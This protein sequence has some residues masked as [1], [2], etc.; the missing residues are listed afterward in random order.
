MMRV[1]VYEWCCSG[2]ARGD[3]PRA[4]PLMAEGWAMLTAAVVDFRRVAGVE[5]RTVLDARLRDFPEPSAW[6]DI[7][8]T[9]VTDDEP[10]AFRAAAADADYALVIAPEFGRILETR[11]RW[12]VES[13]AT[14]LGPSP[15]AVALTADKLALARHF[16]CHGVPTPRTDP[17]A[18]FILSN[19]PPPFVL[20]LRYGAGSEEML[21]CT[22]SITARDIS[23]E[24]AG[25]DEMIMQPLLTG[26]PASVAFLI[27][28]RRVHALLPTEQF[29]SVPGNFRYLGGQLPLPDP[30]A[31]RA[32]RI[33][34]HAIDCIAGLNGFVGVDVVLGNAPDGAGDAAIEIN[35]RLT[36]SCVGLRVAAKDNLMEAMLRLV[37]GESVPK[38]HWHSGR[39]SWTADG[40]V[41]RSEN[42][43]PAATDI[44]TA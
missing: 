30:L 7:A 14:L 34:R 9:W 27:G 26:L 13:G 5:V 38:T 8:I 25:A 23:Y 15:E 29:V 24:A 11:C 42:D 41:T 12:A 33:A 10:A 2:A 35:P 39:V 4:A 18:D 28:P 31:A 32:V 3:S 21:I 44:A 40:T 19:V 37:R 43:P 36:T 22:N 20:K 1:L 16:E 6:S 17:A